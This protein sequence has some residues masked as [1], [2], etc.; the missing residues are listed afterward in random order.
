MEYYTAMKK[1]YW[2][3]QW[4][5]VKWKK[6]DTK[7]AHTVQF[8]LCEAQEQKKWILGDRGHLL[9]VRGSID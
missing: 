1:N 2:Y 4:H 8:Y 3:I 6:A 9:V 5:I 7:R